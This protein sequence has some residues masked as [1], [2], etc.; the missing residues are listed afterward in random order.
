MTTK[1]FG[2][3][4]SGLVF[5]ID[6]VYDDITGKTSFKVTVLEGSLDLNAVY[7]GDGDDTGNESGLQGDWQTQTTKK[8]TVDA[9]IAEDGTM[10]FAGSDNALNMNGVD[11]VWDGGIKLS[12]AGLGDEEG[13]F[14]DN[15]DTDLDGNPC[16][17]FCADG[18]ITAFLATL[19]VRGTSTSTEEGSIKLVGSDDEPVPP[20]EEPDDFPLWPQ[21]ISNV[22]LVFDTT[23]GDT[24]PINDKA[25]GNPNDTLPDGDGYYTVKIDNWPGEADD[26]LDNSIDDILAYLVDNDPNVDAETELLGVVIKGGNQADTEFFAYGD[27]NTNGTESDPL[28][29]GIGFVLPGDSGNVDPTNA[30]DM[31][32]DYDDVFA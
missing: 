16:Y 19:G 20:Q 31:S 12:N 3:Y 14:S 13:T 18:D 25:D 7:W 15:W 5:K 9:G 21:D 29:D 6:V 1:W 27:N 28:P 24:K 23:D 11:E 30:I 10:T 32:Y 22:V 4:E 26:D 8:G 17:E 2:S